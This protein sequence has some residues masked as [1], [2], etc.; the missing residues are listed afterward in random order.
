MTA[1]FQNV[2]T[3]ILTIF[4]DFISSVYNDFPWWFAAGFFGF[5]ILRRL[6]KLFEYVFRQ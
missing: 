3:W 4:K 6:V 1:D 2:G 5:V